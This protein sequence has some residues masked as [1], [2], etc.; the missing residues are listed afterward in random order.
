MWPAE[1]VAP[2]PNSWLKEV[3]ESLQSYKKIEKPKKSELRLCFLPPAPDAKLTLIFD[4]D[5][6][7]IHTGLEPEHSQHTIR[8]PTCPD[9]EV[10]INIRPHALYCLAHCARMGYQ[11]VIFTASLQ[12]YADPIIDTFLDPERQ[13]PRLYRPSCVQVHDFYVKD[14]RCIANRRLRDIFL[15]DNSV[16]SFLFQIKNGIP[17]LPYFWSESDTELLTLVAYLQLLVDS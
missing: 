12:S 13:Y 10:G 17:I 3:Q 4:L 9:E 14:L 1:L 8:L 7:L 2:V 6:T 16:I 11:V 15:V 5:E